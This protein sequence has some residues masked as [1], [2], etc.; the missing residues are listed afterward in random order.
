MSLNRMLAWFSL[1]FACNPPTFGMRFGANPRAHNGGGRSGAAAAKRAA[2]KRR[3]VR[4]H[5]KG[6]A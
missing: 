5:P 6:A 2:R 4:M 1:A 3:N